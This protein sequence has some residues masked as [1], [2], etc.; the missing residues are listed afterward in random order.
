MAVA[1][2]HDGTPFTYTADG[3]AVDSDGKAVAGAP[4]RGPNTDPS[5]Q[6]GALGAPTSE[7]R[8]GMAIANALKGAPVA[9]APKA[10]DDEDDHPKKKR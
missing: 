5:K 4:K 9:H 3:V 7:E 6:P 10:D 8:M 1:K 2:Q